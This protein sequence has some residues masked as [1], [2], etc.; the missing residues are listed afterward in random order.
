MGFG[1]RCAADEQR[2]C[3]PASLHFF[4]DTN[5]FVERW[6]DQSR[7]P[8]KIGIQ[9][10]CRVQYLFGRHHNAKIFDVV[11]IALQ[12]DANNLFTNVVDV[13]F[14]GR[15]DDTPFACWNVVIGLLLFDEW[16]KV[17]HCLLH[18][19]RALDHLR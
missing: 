1:G 10:F 11:S 5:H 18:D 6:R 13:A 3:I 2:L 17:S 4:R 19:A 8:N 14:H 9:G 15:H 16:Y 7:K 12:N